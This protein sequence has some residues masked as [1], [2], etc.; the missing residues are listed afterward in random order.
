MKNND[1]MYQSLLS[2]YDEYQEKK[3]KRGLFIKRTV[4]ILACFCLTVV[5]GLGYYNHLDRP[6]DVPVKPQVTD[7]ALIET[8][9]TTAPTTTAQLS[10]TQ[11]VTQTEAV[12]T[13]VTASKANKTT[14][15]AVNHIHTTAV[16][17]T[18]AT[19]S[20][21][22]SSAAPSIT[23]TAKTTASFTNT[24]VST[25]T[26]AAAQKD[27]P[28]PEVTQTTS[29]EPIHASPGIS[30]TTNGGSYSPISTTDVPHKPTASLTVN[31]YNSYY[32]RSADNSPINTE[33][34]TGKVIPVNND[35]S[36]SQDVSKGIGI[37][38]DIESQ[39]YT[40]Y[41]STDN[42]N[43]RWW[44]IGNLSAPVVSFGST[45][46]IG[47]GGTILWEPLTQNHSES[48][49]ILESY[50]KDNN[51]RYDKIVITQVD[52]NSFTAVLKDS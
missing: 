5:I 7:D 2:R 30:T 20:T 21:K 34:V 39:G 15:T 24:Q 14:A 52:D 17:Y 8:E 9:T 31:V 42:G 36:N 25:S 6:S 26:K 13:A 1:E 35:F 32:H 49:I 10:V 12:T 45:Y 48:T 3:K 28:F 41:L 4:P 51:V 46:S 50:D 44:D 40:T 16:T 43:F 47:D 18:S 37:L 19:R 27:E 22:P 29:G 38:F 33:M 23:Q 11:T